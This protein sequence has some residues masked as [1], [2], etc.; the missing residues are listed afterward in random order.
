MKAEQQIAAMPRSAVLLQYVFY[1]SRHMVE[2]HGVQ[3][4]QAGH[5]FGGLF[6]CLRV[7]VEEI[8]G[9]DVEVL[10]DIEN[11]VMEGSVFPLSMLLM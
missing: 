10:A 3:A 8:A 6:R 9:R 4:F 7:E 5:H 1:D 11:P 2:L